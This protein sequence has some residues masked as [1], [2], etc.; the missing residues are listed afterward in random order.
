MDDVTIPRS[1]QNR[2]E[3]ISYLHTA[4]LYDLSLQRVNRPKNNFSMSYICMFQ[5]TRDR[6]LL[7]PTKLKTII[8]G[9]L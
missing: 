2:V 8:L 7:K 5:F 4:C 6:T 9:S 3:K 1:V